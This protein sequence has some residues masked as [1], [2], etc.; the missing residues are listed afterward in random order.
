MVTKRLIQLSTWFFL[1]LIACN[2]SNQDVKQ[3]PLQDTTK[4]DT[5]VK[6]SNEK[7]NMIDTSSNNDNA[8]PNDRFRKEIISKITNPK[9]L[10]KFD[11]LLTALDKKGVSFCDFMQRL[12]KLDDSCYALAKQKYPDPFQQNEFMKVHDK[13]IQQAEAKYLKSLH[14]RKDFS[15]FASVAYNFDQDIKNFCGTY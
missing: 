11:T 2:N 12:Y 10:K 15:T 14:L 3:A 9:D 1:M 8:L 4:L 7:T 13:A 5:S 6:V